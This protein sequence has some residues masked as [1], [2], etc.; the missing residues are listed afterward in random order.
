MFAMIL[1]IVFCVFFLRTAYWCCF[2]GA[3]QILE[4]QL[5]YAFIMGCAVTAFW[6]FTAIICIVEY[7]GLK[8]KSK[9]DR[10][11]MRVMSTRRGMPP[12]QMGYGGYGGYQMA[13]GAPPQQLGYGY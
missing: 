11:M 2:S 3:M 9:T 6:F 1:F 13:Y 5:H 10:Y 12:P 8:K 4:F 7:M